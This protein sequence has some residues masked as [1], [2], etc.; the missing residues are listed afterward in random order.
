MTDILKRNAEE[1]GKKDR[2]LAERLLNY[3]GEGVIPEQAKSGEFTFRLE[4]RLFHSAYDPAKE[5]VAQAKQILS[6]KPD[7]VLLFG[8]GCGH[9]AAALMQ[10]GIKNVLVYEP[11][12]EILNGVLRA[13]DLSE[14]LKNME[15]F[16]DITCFISRV[17]DIDAFDNI[18]CHSTDPYKMTFPGELLDFLNRVNN[19]QIMSKAGVSTDISSRESWVLNYLEN[20]EH[21]QT[22]PSIDSLRDMFKGVPLVIA[23]A[24]PSL[25]K[26]AHLLREIKGKAVIIAA[27]TAY[28]PLLKFGVVPDFIIA[29]EKVDLPEYFTYDG[30]DLQTRLILGD[31]SHPN[32]FAR[33]VKD[34]FVFFNSYS[35]LSLEHATHWGAGYFPAI[36]GSVTTTA[37]DL[38]IMMGCDPVIFV[39]QDLSFG[40]GETHAPG[41]VYIKQDISIDKDSGTVSIVEDYVTLKDRAKNSHKLLWLKGLD[42]KTVASKYD[43]VTFHQWFEDY[44]LALKKSGSP[45]RVLNATEGGAY[46]EGME[47]LTLREAIDRHVMGAVDI[48]GTIAAATAHR[49][50]PDFEA[51]RS[52][53]SRMQN[54]LKGM[55]ASADA[56]VRETGVI[57]NLLASRAPGAGVA[58]SAGEIKKM[59]KKLFKFAEKTPFIWECLTAENCVL[60]EYLRNSDG[61]GESGINDDVEAISMAYARMSETVGRYIEIVRQAEK[62]LDSQ[63][64]A[65]DKPLALCK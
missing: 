51:L 11:S 52:S 15:I 29:S 38:G 43:W 27:I 50:Q 25:R 40:D 35:A 65:V 18:L 39:G 47:H 44:M 42:G 16:D 1:I 6:R 56:I 26:N 34:K 64:Y 20:M 24:G 8:L 59:E 37:L 12:A 53:L 22:Y 57:R 49:N 3:G 48:N 46:I 21:F 63:D 58:K 33:N 9:L 17:R 5:A 55:K 31:V 32:M 7:W 4:G 36:G 10:N 45:V 62:S 23:G 28:K 2:A 54:G 14:H 19:A 13:V 60:K 30:N 61:L 41:G